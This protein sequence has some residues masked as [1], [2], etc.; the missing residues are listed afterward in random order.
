MA[1]DEKPS[2]VAADA[3][4]ALPSQAKF[5]KGMR[6]TLSGLAAKPELNGIGGQVEFFDSDKDRWAI[7][8]DDEKGTMLFK[9]ANLMDTPE[10]EEMRK[11]MA[12]L[13]AQLDACMLADKQWVIDNELKVQPFPD[14][15][16]A[17][18]AVE[19]HV[20]QNLCGGHL[21]WSQF[22]KEAMAEM[23]AGRQ[24]M[25]PLDDPGFDPRVKNFL[26]A[27]RDA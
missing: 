24:P 15:L 25:M 23:I 11:G 4:K 14:D 27:F 19:W 18:A 3:E 12:R 13:Q 17:L 26:V 21:E 22:I 2:I 16:D 6:V 1:D 8:L 20:D 10:N 7:K 9:E 5:Q